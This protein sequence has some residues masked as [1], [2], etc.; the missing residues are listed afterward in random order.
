MGHPAAR[1]H[2]RGREDR[3][4]L[5]E[6]RVLRLSLACSDYDRTAALRDGTVAPEGIELVY[7]ALPVEETFYRMLRHR[8]FDVAEMS[9]SSY[10]VSLLAGDPWLVA[11]PVFPSRAFRHS[12]VFVHRGSGI[13]RPED[14]RGKVVGVAEY[15][16]TANVWIRGI[17]AEHHGVPVQ[18]VSYRTAG[19]EQPERP[20]KLA[21]DLPADVDLAPLGTGRSLS[22]ALAAGEIDALYTPR[23]PSSFLAGDPAVDR[24]WPDA[25]A[26]ETAYFADTGIFPI[27]HVIVI[28]RALH[29]RHPWIARSLFKAFTAA[30]DLAYERLRETAALPYMLPFLPLDQERV[31]AA[32]GR[33][34]WSYGLEPNRHVLQTFLRY[35]HEQG[36]SARRIAPEELF[37]PE[38]LDAFAI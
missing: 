32:M 21:L 37:V 24:L 6:V 18:A 17:L 1:G 26:A 33:D 23:A 5:E 3:A 10:A 2:P 11:I 30:R 20:E 31:V 12:G 36:L 8:E 34:F 14:L 7:L 15:Q 19:L 16:L 27:M 9:L 13:E 29:E 25:A 28:R 38:V 22:S 4:I 35:H